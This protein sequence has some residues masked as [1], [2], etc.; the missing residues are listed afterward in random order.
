MMMWRMMML[1]EEENDDVED[2]DFFFPEMGRSQ[3]CDPEFVPMNLV[4]YKHLRA[5]KQG[6]LF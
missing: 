2:D 3:D 6:P 1:R 4:G 5:C